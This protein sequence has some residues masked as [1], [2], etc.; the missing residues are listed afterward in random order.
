MAVYA[1]GD[2]QGCYDD[3][4][5][6]L[7]RIRF[8]ERNDTLWLCGDLVNRGPDSLQTLRFVRSLG[9][10]AVAVLGNHDLH[11]LALY[12]S[13]RP[14]NETDTLYTVLHAGDRDELMQWLQ[15]RPLL[16]YDDH[17]KALLVHAGIHP[18]WSVEQARGYAAEVEAVLRGSESRG[19]FS[20]MYGDYPELWSDGLQGYDR[21][22]CITNILTRMRF[23]STD[24]RLDMTAKGGLAHH[25]GDDLVPWYSLNPRD[26]EG[27][28]IIF[29]HWSTLSVGAYG[30][31][32]ALDGGCVWGGKLVALKLDGDAPEWIGI[33]CKN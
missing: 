30:R 5:R 20:Q 11:L 29:G 14:V 3:L 17:I 18:Q 7:D 13:G 6:L 23:F 31:H 24:G 15:S 9:E 26:E 10:S 27:V 28:R 19:Y 16:H 32:F 21:L 33:D 1:I 12:Y 25:R 22:R 8:N 4:V 2:I